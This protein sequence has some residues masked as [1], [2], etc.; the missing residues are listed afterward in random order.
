MTTT[1]DL[2]ASFRDAMRVV[3]DLAPSGRFADSADKPAA[4]SALKK[5]VIQW[6]LSRPNHDDPRGLLAYNAFLSAA[7][8]AEIFGQELPL[9]Y[10]FPALPDFAANA[11]NAAVFLR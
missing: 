5:A 1:A 9:P 8:Y 6:C 4:Y 7:A 11:T 3:P 2:T 10:P